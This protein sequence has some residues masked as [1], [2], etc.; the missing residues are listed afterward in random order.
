MNYSNIAMLY[1]SAIMNG[2]RTYDSVPDLVKPQVREIL[3]NEG[4]Y[5]LVGE[6]AP[7]PATSANINI[8][9]KR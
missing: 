7:Q 3:I 8:N 2:W 1:A 9:N 4:L 6:T 5:E